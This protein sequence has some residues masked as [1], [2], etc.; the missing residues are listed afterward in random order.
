MCPET[1]AIKIPTSAR[2]LPQKEQPES[3]FDIVYFDKKATRQMTDGLSLHFTKVNY[4]GL[5]IKIS[6]TI[7]YSFASSEVIQ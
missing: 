6:S 1:P 3:Y 5:R 2:D 4:F 7:P